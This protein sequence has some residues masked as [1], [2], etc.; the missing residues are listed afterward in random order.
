[1]LTENCVKAAAD[2]TK[3]SHLYYVRLPE[4]MAEMLPYESVEAENGTA[5]LI[6]KEIS[7]ADMHDAA[8]KIREQGGEIFFA[9]IGG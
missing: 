4:K 5:R 8:K 2:N 1:M 7:V 6:T 9:A 3:C